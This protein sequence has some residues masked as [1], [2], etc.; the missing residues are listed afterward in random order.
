[1]GKIFKIATALFLIGIGGFAIFS[2]LSEDSVFASVNEE[3]FTLHELV[4]DDVRFNQMDFEFKNRDLI[5][6]TS[7]DN[8]IKVSYYTTE[9]D[10]VDVTEGDTKL[11]LENDV[12]WWNNLFFGWGAFTNDEFYDVYLYL[13]ST[14]VYSIDIDTSNGVFDVSDMD[15]IDQLEL[16]T[17]NGRV[18]L[19]DVTCNLLNVNTSNGTINLVDV[20]VAS[21]IDANT[22]NGR[23][24]LTNVSATEIDADSSNGKIIA[25]GIIAQD[26]ALETSNGDIEL[27]VLGDREDY[28][29]RMDTSNG[30]M[31]YDGIGVSQTSFN[32]EGTLS[33]DLH[34]SNGDIDLRFT[35]S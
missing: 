15:Q 14:H 8:Q 35:E 23:I 27:E 10:R 30:D 29:V 18:T 9:N 3:D 21:T 6:R 22:S 28:A 4:Y 34:T 1:M 7:E 24:Y 2:M 11:T 19:E 25:S 20:E 16:S 32:P 13:P 26:I 12:E 17:S 5:I 31:N 33:I